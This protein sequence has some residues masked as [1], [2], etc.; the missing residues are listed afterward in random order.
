MWTKCLGGLVLF[1]LTLAGSVSAELTY[2]IKPWSELSS[3]DLTP[4]GRTVLDAGGE[5]WVHAESEHFLFH[6]TSADGLDILAGEAEYAYQKAISYLGATPC[7]K[8]HLFVIES[9]DVWRQIQRRADPSKYGLAMQ[10]QND[11]FILQETNWMSRVIRI[12]HE[13]VHFRLWQLY[14]ERTP[15]WLDEGMASCLGWRIAWWYRKSQGREVV[16][17]LPAVEERFLLTLDR[18]T[19]QRRYPEARGWGQAFYRQV[20]ELVGA[21]GDGL[22][23]DRMGDFVRAVVN[24]E[25]PWKQALREHFG[26]TDGDLATLEQT[27]RTRSLTAVE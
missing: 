6:A 14:G 4:L 9:A 7:A 11:L 15:I 24:D 3:H 2:V 22:G 18:L 27:V 17:S 16:R 8:G 13:V 5:H 1:A 25:M 19:A 10:L 12:P 26:Y 20:D 21:I 23:F